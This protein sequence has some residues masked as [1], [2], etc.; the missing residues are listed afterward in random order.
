MTR[1]PRLEI[2]YC[3]QCRWLL[4]AG[5]TAQELLTTFT[6]ELGEVALIPPGRAVSST[7]GSTV[8]RCGHVRSRA[9]SLSSP[10]SSVWCGTG[11]PPT[12][13]SGTRTGARRPDHALKAITPV[14]TR[15]RLPS[16]GKRR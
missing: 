10:S 2:E 1:Q 4:R 9:V 11:S 15:T 7:S 13:T 3:T 12:G 16:Q 5:W 6:V 14:T 8:T